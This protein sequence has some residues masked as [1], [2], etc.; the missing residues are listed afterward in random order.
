VGEEPGRVIAEAEDD[1]ESRLLPTTATATT[2]VAAIANLTTLFISANLRIVFLLCCSAR[3][4]CREGCAAGVSY[5]FQTRNSCS[6]RTTRRA[7]RD[8]RHGSRAARLATVG[9][10]DVRKPW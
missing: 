10:G 1:G 6:G 5:P 3:M 8:G 7:C 9:Y 2:A 4:S